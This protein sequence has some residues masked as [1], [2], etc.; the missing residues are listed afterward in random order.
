MMLSTRQSSLVGHGRG[1]NPQTP[2]LEA[3]ILPLELTRQVVFMPPTSKKLRGNI[4]LGRSV[5][6]VRACSQS[7]IILMHEHS[8]RNR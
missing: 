7:V 8:V 4:G 5:Q 2:S 1:S 6:R 3:D